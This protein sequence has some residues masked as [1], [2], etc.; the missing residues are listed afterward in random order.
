[1]TR[2]PAG[3][4]SIALARDRRVLAVLA[5][6]VVLTAAA[7]S[8]PGPAPSA[9]PRSGP[10]GASTSTRPGSTGRPAKATTTTTPPTTAPPATT[11]P[12]PP[13]PA[14]APLVPIVSPAIPGEGQ[15]RAAG[16][17]LPGGYGIY[18]TEL[19]A[20][21]GLPATGVA[22][23]DSVATRLVLYAGTTDPP[24]TFAN[25]GDIP[26]AAQATLMAAFD[27][28]FIT[29]VY[30][31]GWYAQGVTAV[32][33]QDGMASLVI[34]TNGTATVGDWGRDVTMGPNVVAVRQN[35]TL[36]VDGGA[37]VASAGSPSAWGAVLGGGPVT[38]RSG[39]G[40]TAAGDLVYAGGNNLDPAELGQVLVAAG[41][42]R[43]MELDINPEWVSF[44]TFTH[45]GG[46]G[47]TGVTGANLTPGMYQ[48]PNHYL[49]PYGRDF[50]AV[51]AR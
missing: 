41:A 40:V 36:L 18:T 28:G 20:G 27:S 51:F 26:V 3:N 16:D 10:P 23:I 30:H 44:A 21:A 17:A 5:A 46:L 45:S 35:L 14:P 22:W 38:W 24:G 37:V 34:D 12:P 2:F 32:P 25:Q 7:C 11:P 50:F 19:R 39:I 8:G 13:L 15:W 49:A 6:T 29:S 31:T 48:S 47:G 1:M 43:A 42:V 9:A 4:R 33:L